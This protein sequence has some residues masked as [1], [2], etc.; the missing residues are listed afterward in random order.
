MIA[1]T[2]WVVEHL[3]VIEDIPFGLFPVQIIL[4]ADAFA[5]GQLEKAI[6]DGVV[7]AI[8]PTTHAGNQAISL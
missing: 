2:F 7:A 8:A 4:V 6:G 3:D 1:T 5:L